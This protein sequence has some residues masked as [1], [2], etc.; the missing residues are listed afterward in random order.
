M[1]VGLLCM[2]SVTPN[3]GCGVVLRWEVG[4]KG[5]ALLGEHTYF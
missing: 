4:V 3:T 2:N 5:A 1:E